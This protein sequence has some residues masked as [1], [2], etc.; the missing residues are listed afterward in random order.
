M[1]AEISYN[2]FTLLNSAVKPEKYLLYQQT[3][4]KLYEHENRMNLHIMTNIERIMFEFFR[5][6]RFAMK[7]I[8]KSFL[9]FLLVITVYSQQKFTSSEYGFEITFPDYITVTKGTAE[10]VAVIA[11]IDGNAYLSVVAGAVGDTTRK[12]MEDYALDKFID[13]LVNSLESDLSGFQKIDYGREIY[14]GA[15]S[16]YFAYNYFKDAKYTRV[17]QYFF[18]NINKMF[19]ITTQCPEAEKD[20]YSVVFKECIKSFNF[21]K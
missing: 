10:G 19:A 16:I 6:F 1:I 14:N 20:D 12:S 2:L 7:I 17:K 4:F 9:F 15:S 3:C 5:K 13:T 18:I 11:D 8:Q 21:V